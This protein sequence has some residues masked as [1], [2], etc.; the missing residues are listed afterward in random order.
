MRKKKT[1]SDV[2]KEVEDR[3]F[4]E[5]YANTLAQIAD[6]E[7]ELEYLATP[8]GKQRL[9]DEMGS[10]ILDTQIAKEKKE[11]EARKSFANFLKTKL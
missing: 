2:E 4:W 10:E 7:L 5:K 1:A 6:L 11:L 8:S 9:K 3:F